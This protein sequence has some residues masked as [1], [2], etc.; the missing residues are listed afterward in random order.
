MSKPIN[1]VSEFDNYTL[2]VSMPKGDM[3]CTYCPC[4]KY[5]HSI[6]ARRCNKTWE[7]LP[8]Y[9][10]ARGIDCPLIKKED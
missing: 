1:G 6:D 3:G 5:D 8:D 10:H 9:K 2:T 7:I 4:V